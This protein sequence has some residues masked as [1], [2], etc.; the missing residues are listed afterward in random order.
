MLMAAGG[1]GFLLAASA[2]SAQNYEGPPPG[3]YG[4]TNEQIIVTPPPYARERGP[5]GGP[6]ED[7]AI[8]RPVRFDDLD[9][10]TAWGA[11]T[12]RERI[13]FAATTMCRQLDMMYPV[14]VS[15]S[16]PCYRTAV[17]P[18]MFQAENAIRY[19][20]GSG[21]EDSYGD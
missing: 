13:R 15:N 11:E 8:S 7:V 21:G 12:L 4:A 2:A 1:V 17:E 18:A 20:R 6:I 14:A 19:A 16:P 10:R 5:N 9:L 3:Y